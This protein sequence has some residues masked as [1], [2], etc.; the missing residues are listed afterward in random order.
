MQRSPR[1]RILDVCFERIR[2][3]GLLECLQ[4]KRMNRPTRFAQT[5]PRQVACAPDMLCCP[6]GLFIPQ[7]LHRRV[8]LDDHAGE[9]LRERVVNVT[10]HAR[11][12]FE[13]GGLALLLTNLLP[14]RRNHD[15]MSKCLGEFYLL[16][17]TR[18]AIQVLNADESAHFSGYKHR[19]NKKLSTP[20][21]H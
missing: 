12:F 5:F 4:T 6:F 1:R 13:D 18:S 19:D 7:R 10:G 8:Q 9:S 2:E 20:P 15:V 3:G 14:M 11:S 16:R 21:V 17:T